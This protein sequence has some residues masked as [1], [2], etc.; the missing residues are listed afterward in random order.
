MYKNLISFL[1]FILTS[2]TAFAQTA[3]YNFYSNLDSI[4]SSGF[5]NIV[6]SPQI[7]A[8]LKTDYSDEE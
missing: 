8:H 6:L 4:K 7:N 2:L 5:Y 1:F 3:G